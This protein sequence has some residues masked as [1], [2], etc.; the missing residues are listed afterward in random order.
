MFRDIFEGSFSFGRRVA[1]FVSGGLHELLAAG[2]Y[3]R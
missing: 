1:R 2:R 3:F